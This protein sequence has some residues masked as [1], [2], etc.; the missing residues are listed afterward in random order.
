MERP[1]NS[2]GIL[3]CL[4]VFW[5]PL[6]TDLSTTCIHIWKNPVQSRIIILP[7]VKQ[8]LES[9]ISGL[10]IIVS[11]F[12]FFAGTDECLEC[13]VVHWKDSNQIVLRKLPRYSSQ[14]SVCKIVIGIVLLKW[15][16]S[17][18]FLL[19]YQEKRREEINKKLEEA[20]EKEK[21]TA[22][23]QRRELFST[24]RAKQAEL[25]RLERKIELTELVRQN[26]DSW[27]WLP[28]LQGYSHLPHTPYLI[29]SLPRVIIVKFL[30]Q[31]HQKYYTT[32]YGEL[33]FS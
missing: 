25:R 7:G 22:A 11:N 3:L 18:W 17:Y 29:L 6:Y 27:F 5:M 1:F 10:T 9:K 30:L 21:E 28:F 8:M 33:G 2:G 14:S 16:D 15:R 24:R 23:T 19:W 20:A 13:Y 12:S 4:Y 31:P 26:K 32:H